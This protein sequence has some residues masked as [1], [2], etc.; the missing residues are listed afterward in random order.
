MSSFEDKPLV[1]TDLS[2]DDS[3]MCH[4]QQLTNITFREP[5]QLQPKKKTKKDSE[6]EKEK[7]KKAEKC[8][9]CIDVVHKQY[10]KTDCG[11]VFCLT[12][13]HEHL[14]TNHTCPLCRKEILDEKPKKPI[15]EVKRE[16]AIDLINDELEDYDLSMLLDKMVSF[17]DTAKS[18]IKCLM[19]E[20]GLE[21]ADKFIHAQ[22]Y[23]DDDDEEDIDDYSYGE[24]SYS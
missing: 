21:L 2:T 1:I 19:Q 13:L 22:H 9:I 14:K 5:N 17:P 6:K 11:H 15:L 10:S 8:A 20:Y 16:K 18:R 12:C 7:I 24:D 3:E 23:D 4:S